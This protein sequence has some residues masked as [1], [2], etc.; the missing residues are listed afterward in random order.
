MLILKPYKRE[1]D[2]ILSEPRLPLLPDV[3]GVYLV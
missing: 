2:Q 3:A 1:V